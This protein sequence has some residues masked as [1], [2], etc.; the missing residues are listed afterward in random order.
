MNINWCE[1]EEV[2]TP[3]EVE[4][5]VKS[6]AKTSR[7]TRTSTTKAG[8]TDEEFNAGNY[9]FEVIE[10]ADTRDNSKIYLV[11]VA[12]K[13]SREEYLQMNK[14]IK[15]LGGYYSK[16]K[17]AFLFKDDPTEILKGEKN[18]KRSGIRREYKSGANRAS[19]AGG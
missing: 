18:R 6:T 17:H 1:L 19:S 7:G 16:F 10:D 2:K 13:L 9:T 8:A 14:H 12:E 3:Y 5:V 15:S 11:K 4:K